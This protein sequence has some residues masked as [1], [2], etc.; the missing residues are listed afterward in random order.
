MV[1]GSFMAWFKK[2]V[3]G[4]VFAHRQF[5]DGGQ[6]AHPTKYSLNRY[7]LFWKSP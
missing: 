5:M 3:V 4:K 7:I 1:I 2:S 6:T